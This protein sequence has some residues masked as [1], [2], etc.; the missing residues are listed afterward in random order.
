MFDQHAK[1][2]KIQSMIPDP[3]T[4]W[5]WNEKGTQLTFL[6]REGVTWHDGRPFSAKDVKCTWD[7]LTGQSSAKLRRN[8]AC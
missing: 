7:L 6:L 5:S 1:Q 4:A 2:N 3:A 8:F